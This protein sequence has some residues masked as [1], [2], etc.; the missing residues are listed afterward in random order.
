MSIL[1]NILRVIQIILYVVSAFV[2]LCCW[3]VA[4]W[5]NQVLQLNLDGWGMFK[6]TFLVP[7]YVPLVCVAIPG[8][9]YCAASGIFEGIP[10]ILLFGSALPL[11]MTWLLFG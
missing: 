11:V 5:V 2:V 7:F 4:S 6:L 3:I 10:R 9:L 8:A 1:V